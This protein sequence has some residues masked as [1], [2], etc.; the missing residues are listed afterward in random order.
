MLV[1]IISS[2]AYVSSNTQF[3]ISFVLRF[4]GHG[5]VDI[6]NEKDEL[7]CASFY[8][9]LEYLRNANTKLQFLIKQ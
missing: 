6:T 7:K 8:S 3:I 9:V 2:V 4:Q 1:L 5:F